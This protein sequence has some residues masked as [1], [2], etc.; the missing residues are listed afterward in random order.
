MNGQRL[1]LIAIIV[2]LVGVLPSSALQ[3]ILLVVNGETGATNPDRQGLPRSKAT[4]IHATLSSRSWV[5]T[6]TAR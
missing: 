5:V 3:P 2:M 6:R 1:R 4:A